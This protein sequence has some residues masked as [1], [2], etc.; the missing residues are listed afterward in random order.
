MANILKVT[1]PTVEKTNLN[2]VRTENSLQPQDLKIQNPVSTEKVTRPDVRNDAAPEGDGQKLRLNYESNFSAFVKSLGKNPGMLGPLLQLMQNVQVESGIGTDTAKE[3]SALL[4]MVQANEGELPGL[5]KNQLEAASRFRNPFFD[6]LRQALGETDSPGLQ[7]ELLRFVKKYV[8]VTSAVHLRN[9]IENTLEEACGR[10]LKNSAETLNQKME[11]MFDG[12]GGQIVE[13]VG[14]LKREILPFLNAYITASH[15][16]GSLR[17]LT[18]R[19][20]LLISRYE[21]ADRASLLEDYARLQDYAVFQ[22]YFGKV[23]KTQFDALLTRMEEVQKQNNEENQKFID[24]IEG[25][26]TGKEGSQVK[27]LAGNVLRSLLLNESVYMP[28]LHLFLPMNVDDRLIYS[29]MWVDPDAAKP[30]GRQ[31]ENKKAVKA[32]IKFDIQDVGFFD[33]Y[34]Y[35]FDGKAEIQLNYPNGLKEKEVEIRE[36]MRRIMRECGIDC[37]TLVLDN[38]DNSIPLSEA[39]PE[40]YERRNTINVRV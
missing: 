39:F 5:M 33:L 36:N 24:V 11:G 40:I 15:D 19:L 30:Q 23:D 1:T 17:E 25:G 20:A 29:E 31:E 12:N 35:F 14:K 28:L 32:L 13:E 18:A 7:Q 21:N 10:M 4:K 6:L 26:L 34:L 2:P 38:S 27:Q 16:R 22:K 9:Q 37:N 8:D 3:I